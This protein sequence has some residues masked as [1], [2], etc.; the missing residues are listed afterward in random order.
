MFEWVIQLLNKYVDERFCGVTHFLFS[1]FQAFY[2]I[3]AKKSYFDQV[4][5]FI[6]ILVAISWTFFTG[7]CPV[8][9]YYKKDKDKNYQAGDESIDLSDMNFLSKDVLICVI[10]LFCLMHAI[11]IYIVMKRN[12]YPKYVYYSVPFMF[13]FYTLSLRLYSSNLRKSNVF[14]AIQEFVKFYLI[15]ILVIFLNF[16]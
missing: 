3:L 12:N 14:L 4:Y 16:Q 1:F 11:S 10:T 2:G 7:E 15:L 9:Y 5:L 13:I 8:S 6:T